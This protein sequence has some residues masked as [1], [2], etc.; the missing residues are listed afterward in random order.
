MHYPN[1]DIA[2]FQGTSMTWRSQSKNSAI[3]LSRE[4]LMLQGCPSLGG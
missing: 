2:S 1:S 4:A 3:H